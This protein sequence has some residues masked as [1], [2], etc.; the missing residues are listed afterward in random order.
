M[1]IEILQILDFLN[2][3]RL[4]A[5]MIFFLVF[6]VLDC[7]IKRIMAY[8]SSKLHNKPSLLS[9]SIF[10][11]VFGEK[12]EVFENTLKSIANQEYFDIVEKVVLLDRGSEYDE[13]LIQISE[14]YKF[15]TIIS[16]KKEGKRKKISYAFTRAI[17]DIVIFVDS[18][19]IL[20][21]N[22]VSEIMKA[23]SD[24]K[25]GGVQTNNSVY[26]DNINPVVYFYSHLIES[27][28]NIINSGLTKYKSLHVIDGRCMAWRKSAVLP[29]LN[30]F[31]NDYFLGVKGEIGDDRQLTRI[32]YKH[33]YNT[34]YQPTA[35]IS[36]LPAYTFFDF[37]RQQLRWAR[38]GYKYLLL[39][40]K[41]GIIFRSWL[42]ALHSILYY[43][44][45]FAFVI[46]LFI[47]LFIIPMNIPFLENNLLLSIVFILSGSVL[48][49]MFRQ[50]VLFS[51]KIE[52]SK[53]NLKNGVNNVFLTIPVGVMGLVIMFPLF[54][55]AL[56][57]VKKQNFWITRNNK[58]M[59]K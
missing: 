32:L 4:H 49:S 30:E 42:Y 26:G 37:I 28:R 56:I 13:K 5:L 50:V 45:P 3:G 12:P 27:G 25:V 16:E 38:S 34:T 43:S 35:K 46:T 21:K 14:K 55:Y 10:V 7:S 41:D 1:F 24:E 57:T 8:P 23:F 15:T 29:Y 47:D 9:V 18:D 44:A 19:T 53:E 58:N 54:I 36:T 11:P 39:D 20:E 40:I 48:V 59:I 51:E 17:G 22:C 52:I 2:T 31:T 6:V 33:N